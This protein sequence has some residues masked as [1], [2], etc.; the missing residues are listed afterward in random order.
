M[1]DGAEKYGPYNWRDNGVIASV[2]VDAAK[3]HLDKWFEGQ[4]YDPSKVHHLGHALACC[5]ILLDAQFSDGL[6]DDRP[7]KRD[8]EGQIINPDK[9]ADFMDGLSDRIKERRNG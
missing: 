7:V 8:D 1:M 2:Y 3:R 4:E 5:A 9:Y 6:I